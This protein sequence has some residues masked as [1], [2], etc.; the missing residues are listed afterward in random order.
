[1]I[2][3]FVYVFRVE[4]SHWRLKTMLA[5]SRGDLS[6]RWDVVNTMLKLHL[7][8][9]RVSIQKKSMQHWVSTNLNITF[10]PLVIA[11][12]TTSSRKYIITVG[13]VNNNHLV[14]VKLKLNVIWLLSHTNRD[15]TI[16]RLQE[17]G[18]Q[19]MRDVLDIGNK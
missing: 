10:F 17:H 8:S 11:S 12:C 4:S 16:V 5:S 3:C 1:M 13:F 9:I 14:Q 7:G 2:F 6:R 19:H 15:R 18:N